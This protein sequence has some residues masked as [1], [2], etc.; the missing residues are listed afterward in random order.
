MLGAVS[1][2]KVIIG[3]SNVTTVELTVLVVPLTVRL[4]SIVAFVSTIS[5]PLILTLS[6][7]V[8]SLL[9]VRVSVF[10]LPIV[11]LSVKVA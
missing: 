11:T 1:P 7:R 6:V 3:S 2:P 10:A 4:P 5:D 8:V 9:T